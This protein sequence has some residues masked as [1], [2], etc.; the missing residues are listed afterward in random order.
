MQRAYDGRRRRTLHICFSVDFLFHRRGMSDILDEVFLYLSSTVTRLQV[1]VPAS[2]CL[3][4]SFPPSLSLSHARS[5]ARSPRFD[6]QQAGE[7]GEEQ[8]PRRSN[9]GTTAATTTTTTTKGE[10]PSRVT[11]ELMS[12]W[13]GLSLSWM[14]L[15]RIRSVLNRFQKVLLLLR[16]V[17]SLSSPCTWHPPSL[18]LVTRSIPSNHNNHCTHT[19]THTIC[20]PANRSAS[21]A[22]LVPLRSPPSS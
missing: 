16:Y 18:P 20:I 7:G 15:V 8:K 19:H 4:A 14:R 2:A 17:A 5:L 12:S 1:S 21:P 10:S 11:S 13:S 22:S 9:R 3:R 6:S